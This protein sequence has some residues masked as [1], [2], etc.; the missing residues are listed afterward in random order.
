MI[1]FVI[2]S[3]LLF[4]LTFGIIAYGYLFGIY[5][6]VQHLT[7]E[8]ARASV[9]GLDDTERDSLVRSFVTANGPAYPF[10]ESGRITVATASAGGVSAPTFEVVVRYDLSGSVVSLF[11]FLPLPPSPLTLRAAVQRGGY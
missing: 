3:P 2:V 5:S 8:A 6:S 10:L 4:S 1:E 9:G 11:P 7:A